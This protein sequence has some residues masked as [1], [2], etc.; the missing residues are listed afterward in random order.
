M[1]RLHTRRGRCLALGHTRRGRRLALGRLAAGDL[2]LS[3]RSGRGLLLLHSR[4]PT[5]GRRAAFCGGRRGARGRRRAGVGRHAAAAGEREL[6]VNGQRPRGVMG[7]VGRHRRR[8]TGGRHQRA[9]HR[10]GGRR[11]ARL[12]VR[13]RRRRWRSAAAPPRSE[14]RPSGRSGRSGRHPRR[15][16]ASGGKSLSSPS[17]LPP[18]LTSK[19]TS[20]HDHTARACTKRGK[21]NPPPGPTPG[22]YL[23]GRHTLIAVVI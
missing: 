13:G 14:R 8:A 17:S 3:D 22:A 6:L 12:G 16:A 19:L 2:G 1:S 9:R 23:A 5:S 7:R 21:Y 18:M 20:H 4:Q 11:Q 10:G 15:A